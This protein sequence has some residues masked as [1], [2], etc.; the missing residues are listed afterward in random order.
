MQADTLRGLIK[1]YQETTCPSAG[2]CRNAPT[3]ISQ[4][5]LPT[6]KAAFSSLLTLVSVALA[7]PQYNPQS[8]F[9]V[10]AQ[11]IQDTCEGFTSSLDKTQDRV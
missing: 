5:Q 1:N 6:M 8:V 2:I 3:S 9:D 10:S 7:V 4:S 11:D